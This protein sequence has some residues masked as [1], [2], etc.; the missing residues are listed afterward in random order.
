MALACAAALIDS[1][2]QVGFKQLSGNARWWRL[3]ILRHYI[4]SWY[5]QTRLVEHTTLII[6]RHH[7]YLHDHRRA[8]CDYP[9]IY[10]SDF[11]NSREASVS[12]DQS[13]ID[14][15]TRSWLHQLASSGDRCRQI[16]RTPWATCCI[17]IRGR[18]IRISM[19]NQSNRV[20]SMD[21]TQLSVQKVLLSM[22]G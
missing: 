9:F 16:T 22:S 1:D 18:Y 14:P 2:V 11:P 13:G 17:V 4:W 12:I 8:A 15:T 21:T 6:V 7:L 10:S 5:T 19:K 3:G 20:L